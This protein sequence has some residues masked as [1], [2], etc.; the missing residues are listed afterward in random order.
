MKRKRALELQREWGDEPCPHPEFSK[1]YD[2]GV[3]TGKFVCTQCGAV[4]TGGE[5]ARI[6]ISREPPEPS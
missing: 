3:R 6:R 2:H 4:L 1:E 5:K